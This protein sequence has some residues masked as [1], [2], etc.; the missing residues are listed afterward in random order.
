[1][2]G[3]GRGTIDCAEKAGSMR[4]LDRVIDAQEHFVGQPE[5]Q[6]VRCIQFFVQRWVKAQRFACKDTGWN[7]YDRCL[8][9]DL[10]ERGHNSQSLTGMIDQGYGRTE[11]DNNSGR[12][13][14]L[15]ECAVTSNNAPIHT[16]FVITAMV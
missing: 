1:M 3:P 5:R 8:C 16:R 9:R 2:I 13:I 7:R 11:L 4:K 10:A 6:R 15:D 12:N 14:S